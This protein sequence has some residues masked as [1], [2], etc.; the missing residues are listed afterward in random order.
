MFFEDDVKE[1]DNAEF[2]RNH[3]DEVM[4]F[5]YEILREEDDPAELN[6]CYGAFY[7]NYHKEALKI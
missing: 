7:R 2:C 3:P 4:A 1:L 5:I 6:L